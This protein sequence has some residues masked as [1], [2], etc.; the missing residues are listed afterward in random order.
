MKEGEAN[1]S[2]EAKSE[3]NFHSLTEGGTKNPIK[4]FF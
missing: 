1:R 4:C 3:K 2:L